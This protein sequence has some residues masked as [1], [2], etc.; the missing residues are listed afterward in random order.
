MRNYI[1]YKKLKKPFWAPSPKVFSPVWIFLYIL[2]LIS[3]GYVFLNAWFGVISFWLL[4]PFVLN[5]IF[6][7]AFTYIQFELRNNALAALDAF[8][9]WLSILGIM[10]VIYPF[11]AIVAYAQVPYLLWVTFATILQLSITKMNR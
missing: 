7:F 3:F 1:Y 5:L 9:L 8:L 6:N 11:S 2:I 4:M 10:Y